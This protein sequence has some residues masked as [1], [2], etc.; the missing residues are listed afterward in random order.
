MKFSSLQENLAEGLQIV[1]RAVPTKGPLPV[2]SNILIST[3]G[4]RIKLAAT[5]LATT[6]TTYI[7]ASVEKKGAITVP[8]KL[9]KDFITNLSPGTINVHLDDDIF[10][11]TCNNSKS[12][13]NSIN[14]EDFPELPETAIDDPLVELDPKIFQEIINLVAFASGRDD[15]RP[16]LAGV[17]ISHQGD[18]TTIASMDGYRLSEKT[19]KLKGVKKDFTAVIPTKTLLEVARIFSKTEETIKFTLSENEN[20]AMFSANDTLVSTR[21]LD[22]QYPPYQQVIPQN[23]TLEAT[24]NTQE[25][26]EAVRLTSVFVT[27]GETKNAIKL[28]MDPDEE[29]IRVISLAEETGEHESRIPAE[30]N[31]DLTEIAFNVKYLLDMLNNVK[32]E[33]MTLRTNGT[34]SPCIFESDSQKDYI[35]IIMPIQI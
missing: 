10:H 27:S 22:G 28:V 24:F 19:L 7:G 6:V 21:L 33:K 14:A 11:V 23:T 32:G 26:M 29:V 1:S 2:L 13:F 17:Y 8:A 15:S 20:Q 18:T 12:K 3:E 5:D 16:I 30:I 4:G 9:L 34:T 25:F 31:G 35:H